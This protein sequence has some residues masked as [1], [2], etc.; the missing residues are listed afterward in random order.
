MKKLFNKLNDLLTNGRDAVLCNI[1]ASTGSTPR[2]EGAKMLVFE[3]EKESNSPDTI[4]DRESTEIKTVG[5]IGGGAV[6]Y[7]ATLIAE[8]LLKTKKSRTDS[9]CLDKNDVLDIGMVCGGNVTVYFR[10]FSSNEK[11]DIELSEKIALSFEKDK[12]VWLITET[13]DENAGEIGF[14]E[15][16][17]GL[18]FS[19]LSIDELKPYLSSKACFIKDK[20]FV[21]PII[22]SGYVYV[23]GGGHISKALVPVISKV[24]FRAVVVEDREKFADISLFEG[25]YKTVLCDFDSLNEKIKV[26][27][28]D[29]IVIMT[30]GHKNDFEILEFSLDTKAKYIGLIGS[31]RKWAHTVERLL[32]DGYTEKDYSRVYNPIGL[33]IGAQTPEEIAVS[34]AAQMIKHRAE[35]G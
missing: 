16:D 21:E 6:E 4:T 10:Y 15:K 20:F 23:F 27:E 33:E 1:I 26:T 19:K 35:N 34:I 11:A 9:F 22:K 17:G 31:K 7:R 25:A 3:E 18:S 8:E 28:N 14:Y 29:Y 24:D 5:T 12:D 2:S 13:S 30:R 32:E